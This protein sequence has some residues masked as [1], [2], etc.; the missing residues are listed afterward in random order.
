[1][2]E[3]TEP[4]DRLRMMNER[5]ESLEGALSRAQFPPSISFPPAPPAAPPPL[6]AQRHSQTGSDISPMPGQEQELHHEGSNAVEAAGEAMAI[7]GLVDLSGPSRPIATTDFDPSRADVISRSM[8]GVEECEAEF[9]LYFDQIQP[10][11]CLLST[12]LDRQ[13]LVVRE[14]SPLLFHAILLITVY[15]RPRTPDNLLLYRNIS[16]ILD[17]ILAPQILSPQPDTLSFDFV[18]AIHLLLL[19]KPV[20][21]N[22]L[23]AKGIANPVLL[24]SASK[25]NVRASWLLRLLVSRVSAFIGLPSIATT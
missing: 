15:Y 4:S 11:T 23:S 22:A 1:M 6:S 13:P 7:E 3:L 24:E 25:M 12:T 5:L 21:Y 18:R 10:W 2:S 14:R 19:Y 9:R 16:S 17:A 8:M 20:Q